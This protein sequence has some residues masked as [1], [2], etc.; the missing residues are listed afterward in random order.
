MLKAVTGK[1]CDGLYCAVIST[2]NRI[3]YPHAKINIQTTVNW[4]NKIDGKYFFAGSRNFS[5]LYLLV[6][7]MIISRFP[8]FPNFIAGSVQFS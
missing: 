8:Q 5:L 4:N 1:D 7:N 6:I 2:G 3:W